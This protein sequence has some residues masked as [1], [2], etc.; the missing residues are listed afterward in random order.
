[1]LLKNERQSKGISLT[2]I[3]KQAN[4]KPQVLYA[5]EVGKTGVNAERAK[6]IAELL[7][8]PVEYFFKPT[9]YKIRE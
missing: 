3:A 6:E 1:M 7:D 8:R 9:Y 4:M 5:I 2:E